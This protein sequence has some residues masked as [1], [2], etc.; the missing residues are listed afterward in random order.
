MCQTWVKG[1]VMRTIVS[2]NFQV[3]L[4]HMWPIPPLF[5]KTL[6]KWSK[7]GISQGCR[8]CLKIRGHQYEDMSHQLIICPTFRQIFEHIR[9]KII[10]QP[11]ISLV[12]AIQTNHR[13]VYQLNSA[14]SNNIAKYPSHCTVHIQKLTYQGP[15]KGLKLV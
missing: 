3:M 2:A 15:V 6:A 1:G 13:C 9:E 11:S 10:K 7:D 4:R 5:G 8:V 12:N 14:V